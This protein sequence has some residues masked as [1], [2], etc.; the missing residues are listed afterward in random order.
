MAI[1]G[2]NGGLCLLKVGDASTGVTIVGPGDATGTHNGH[3]IEL[4]H[5]PSG[6]WRV[7]LDGS[8]S[9]KSVDIALNVTFTD[10]AATEQLMADAFAGVAAVYTMDFVEYN[11]SGTFTPVINSETATKDTAVEMAMTFMSSGEIIR[12]A[13]PT[14][15]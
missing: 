13:T 4:N 11:Y 8:L 14:A 7:N 6:G 1:N 12:T 15:P 5:K 10:D 2:M 9:T 3:P